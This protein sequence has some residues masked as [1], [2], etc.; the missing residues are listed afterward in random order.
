M[1]TVTTKPLHSGEVF[2]VSH[3]PFWPA[4][5]SD[6]SHKVLIIDYL[7][8]STKW[9]RSKNLKDARRLL[10]V[11][12]TAADGLRDKCLKAHPTRKRCIYSLVS[13]KET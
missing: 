7:I 3:A 2:C 12:K 5:H 13:H 8:S 9:I 10:T 4:W 6:I 1:N 11:D